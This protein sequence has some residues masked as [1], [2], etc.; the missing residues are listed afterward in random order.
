MHS[1]LLLVY[2]GKRLLLDV[3]ETWAGRFEQLRPDWIAITHA[4]PDH[5]FGLKSGTVRPVFVTRESF[6]LLRRYPVADF[7]ILR[8]NRVKHIGPFQVLAYPVIHS[9]RAPAVGFRVTAGGVTIVYNPD[10]ISI[11][12]ADRILRGIDAY[13]GDGATLTHPFVR[14]HGDLLFGHT[15]VRAQL[16]WCK[17]YGVPR[18]F[19]AHCGKQL[20]QLPHAVLQ[21]IVS[22]MAGPE[23]PVTVAFDGLRVL[24]RRRTATR[25]FG[26]HALSSRLR[27]VQ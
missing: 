16:G 1:A 8:P 5:S 10:V 6:E 11:P 12:S 2:R 23:L 18:A 7:R 3:G 24:I 13:I 17:R 25:I 22:E 21:R 4:H 14:R 26:K 27:K 15:T 19:I 20:V 9:L